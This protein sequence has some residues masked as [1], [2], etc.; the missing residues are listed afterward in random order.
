MTPD[1]ATPKNRPPDPR[2]LTPP[3]VTVYRANQRHEMSWVGVCVTMTR[4]II[5]SSE[6]IKQLLKRDLFAKYKKSR[7]G[8]LWVLTGPIMQTVPW[9]IAA[10]MN[11]YN[12]GAT[13]VVLGV[14]LLVGRSC[15]SA[16]NG[17]FTGASAT[18]DQGTALVQ[19]VKYP[20][21]ALFIKQMLVELFNFSL[22]FIP[23]LLAMLLYRV[24]PGWGLL[25]FPLTLLPLFF[26]GAAMGLFVSM[27]RVVAY[28]LDRF[29]LLIMGLLMWTAPIL[30]SDT[31][32][33][34]PLLRTINDYNP[35][36]YLICTCRDVLIHGHVYNDAVGV[37]VACAGGS[38]LLFLISLRLFFVSEH[39]LVERMI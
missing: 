36:T 9:L 16:F 25:L 18:L 6:L 29:L 20:H 1:T 33:P 3:P 15:W 35:L 30:Y 27:I 13:T 22:S 4:N 7:I 12:P 19:Q 32:P 8:A 21:E 2:P 17:F 5:G 14:Y 38:L 31:D 10:K 11:V 23:T 26:L 34:H 28:D 39:K 24:Y 37:Y